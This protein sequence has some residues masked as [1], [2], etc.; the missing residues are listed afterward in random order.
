[1]A[2]IGNTL[3]PEKYSASSCWQ[4]C[5][6]VLSSVPEIRERLRPMILLMANKEVEKEPENIDFLVTLGRILYE[7]ESRVASEAV[8]LKAYKLGVAVSNQHDSTTTEVVHLL[9]KLYQA[10]NKPEEA[11]KWRA[12]VAQIEDF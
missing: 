11:E 5:N 7:A 12:K 8:L 10:W 6:L 4:F 2:V 3:K 9:I 1:V